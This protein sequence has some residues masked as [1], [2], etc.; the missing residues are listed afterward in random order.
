[1]SASRPIASELW[2]RSEMTRCASNGHRNY[3]LIL[4]SGLATSRAYSTKSRATGP[5]VRFFSVKMPIGTL[6][7]LTSTGRTSTWRGSSPRDELIDAGIDR[8]RARHHHA[9]DVGWLNEAKTHQLPR[10]QLD[11]FGKRLNP[12]YALLYSARR[13]S[14]IPARRGEPLAG[15][16]GGGV[17]GQKHGDAGD[18]VGLAER[19]ERG[20]EHARQRVDRTLG[21][22]V[23]CR[24]RLRLLAGHR[25]DVDD[26]AAVRAEMLGRFLG[27]KD[28][29][30]H[31][32]VELQV[33]FVLGDVFER[34]EVI[35]AGIIHQNVDA[36]ES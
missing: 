10:R 18:I 11:G 17:G 16:P 26:A 3:P 31:V 15:D 14:V 33:E 22:R 1:M 5:M 30:E 34:L 13:V 20:G 24:C 27:G 19:A 29:A 12:S 28:S 2:H 7:G 6:G 8:T 25:R 4:L 9:G 36:A 35:D 21:G 23:D 32:G